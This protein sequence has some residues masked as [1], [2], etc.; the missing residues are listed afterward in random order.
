MTPVYQKPL[1]STGMSMIYDATWLLTRG[2]FALG[3]T[4]AFLATLPATMKEGA[5]FGAEG[6]HRLA[7]RMSCV[8]V[9]G[10]KTLS[11]HS[12]VLCCCN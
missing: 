8:L 3:G 5:I 10:A 2:S 9:Q 4:M 1:L 6:A 11:R 7:S 12:R